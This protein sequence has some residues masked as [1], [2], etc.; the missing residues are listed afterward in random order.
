MSE[1]QLLSQTQ[2]MNLQKRLEEFNETVRKVA[3]KIDFSLFGNVK[4]AEETYDSGHAVWDSHCLVQRAVLND[5]TEIELEVREN[6]GY[7][8]GSWLEATL[9][10]NGE[11]VAELILEDE[12][13]SDITDDDVVL[14]WEKEPYSYDGQWELDSWVTDSINYGSYSCHYT[15]EEDDC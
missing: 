10:V 14:L 3:E 13:K 6:N 12:E 9:K 4:Y 15:R 7:N 1:K 5:G 2:T 8:L 11:I